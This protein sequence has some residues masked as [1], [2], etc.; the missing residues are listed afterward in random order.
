MSM[1][2]FTVTFNLVVDSN[3]TQWFS[4]SN[5]SHLSIFGKLK[6]DDFK[7]TFDISSSWFPDCITLIFSLAGKL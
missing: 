3:S 6:C 4:D 5:I 7:H 1:C 2:D